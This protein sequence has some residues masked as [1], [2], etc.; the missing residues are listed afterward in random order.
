M[1]TFALKKRNQNFIMWEPVP[2]GQNP[3]TAISFST[4][5]RHVYTPSEQP[6][7]PIAQID[8][9]KMPTYFAAEST[10]VRYAA[11]TELAKGWGPDESWFEEDFT[12]LRHPG[13]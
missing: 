4:T 8:P 7:T 10:S 5:I 1:S 13:R 2:A 9:R 6:R 11:M 12:N 3:F